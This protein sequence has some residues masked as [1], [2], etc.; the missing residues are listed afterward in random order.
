M[1]NII[2]LASA[3]AAFNNGMYDGFLIGK[4]RLYIEGT[5]AAAKATAVKQKPNLAQ[6]FVVGQNGQGEQSGTMEVLLVNSRN[7][8][9][10]AKGKPPVSLQHCRHSEIVRHQFSKAEITNYLSQVQDTNPIHKGEKPV[11][12]GIL[13]LA[14]LYDNWKAASVNWEVR[15]YSPCFAE[16]EISWYAS[17]KQITGV[18]NQ[19]CCVMI[20]LKDR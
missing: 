18:Q 20:T 5:I 4:I 11:V 16:E 15:F 6:L 1:N 12:P 7:A 10:A 17:E 3:L 19:V 13:L 9:Q 14:F 8:V 2:V